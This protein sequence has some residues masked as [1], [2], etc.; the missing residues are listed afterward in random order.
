MVFAGGTGSSN[1]DQAW[2]N[3]EING[4]SAFLSISASGTQL[5][6]TN[7]IPLTVLGVVPVAPAIPT[8]VGT[9]R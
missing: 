6:P 5:D 9:G 3:Y 2:V 8:I 4:P 1:L 7:C